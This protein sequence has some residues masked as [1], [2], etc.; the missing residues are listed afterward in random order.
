M[1]TLQ[2]YS[3]MQVCNST[4]IVGESVEGCAIEIFMRGQSNDSTTL[5]LAGMH[6]DEPKSVYLAQQ[7]IEFL[8]S[9]STIG[10]DIQWIVLPIV[11]PDG[12]Q[13][14]RRR[15]ANRIDI[16]RNFPTS[17]WIRGS[18]RSRMF[19]GE[20]PESEPESQAV[21]QVIEQFLPDRIISIHSIGRN[22]FCNNYDGP[23]RTM[24]ESM[25][26]LN[27]YPVTDTIGYSTPGSFGTWAGIERNIPTITLELPSHH[28]SKRCWKDNRQA[29]MCR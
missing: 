2:T 21:I 5:I 20:S 4:L 29:L 27:G 13:L 14:R 12:F 18:K 11:N 10:Q 8:D 9:D 19:G 6:G 1:T 7:F 24:A 17:N 15:N 25:H 26:R 23:G 16:N 28:S 22:R 3:N